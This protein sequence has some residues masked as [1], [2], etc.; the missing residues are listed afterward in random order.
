MSGQLT[1]RG[2][3]APQDL[4]VADGPLDGTAPTT[5]CPRGMFGKIVR[6]VLFD[7]EHFDEPPAITFDKFRRW[8]NEVDRNRQE[9]ESFVEKMQR[10]FGRQ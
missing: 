6:R 7:E 4:L 1:V 2:K 9:V 3:T 5:R 10:I 8:A